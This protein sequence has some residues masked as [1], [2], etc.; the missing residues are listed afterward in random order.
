MASA[1]LKVVGGLVP[2][3]VSVSAYAVGGSWDN[4]PT[5]GPG[6]L[7]EPVSTGTVAANSTVT[8]SGLVPNERYVAYAL[9]SGAHRYMRFTAPPADERST[10]SPD[11]PD[12]GT[13]RQALVKL[14]D[15]DG[16]AGWDDTAVLSND[17]P[18][19]S[20]LVA[21]AG[22]S[23]EAAR[24]DHVHPPGGDGAAGP[25]HYIGEVGEVDF[26][27][28]WVNVAA[29][30][31]QLSW[32][33]TGDN[34]YLLGGVVDGTSATDAVV[35]TLPVEIQPLERRFFPAT[36]YDETNT[37]RPGEITVEPGGFVSVF[38]YDLDTPAFVPIF[39]VWHLD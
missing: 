4:L 21:A 29:P 18:L 38:Q 12:G 36:I 33:T 8:L 27:N 14:S 32:R 37:A 25:H 2:V 17:D 20:G 5:G 31:Q 6:V 11:L 22:T 10:I 24:A 16:D 1:T 28:G 39:A 9:V 7:G 13:L 26:E 15:I 3:G 19:P 35:C 34:G 30:N 23:G